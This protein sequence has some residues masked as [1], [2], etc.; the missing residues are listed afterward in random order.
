MYRT[1]LS[2]LCDIDTIT[3]LYHGGPGM[4]QGPTCGLGKFYPVSEDEAKALQGEPEIESEPVPPAE[5]E[6]IE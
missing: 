3:V 1:T 5:P 4:T 6:D 2:R